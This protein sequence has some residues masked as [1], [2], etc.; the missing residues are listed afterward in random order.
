MR[1]AWLVPLTEI[2]SSA[3]RGSIAVA[4][5]EALPFTVKRIYTISGVSGGSSR[6][7]H[8]HKDL[9]QLLFVPHGAVTVDLEFRTAR[10]SFRLDSPSRGLVI[11]PMHWRVLRDFV[12]GT[13][14]VVGAS[15]PYEEM[16]YIRDYETFVSLD[17][18][19][20]E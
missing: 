19:G 18:C 15:H 10:T 20:R 5:G 12:N 2:T 14:L 9:W 8:A 6:G 11:P 3:D 1:K 7:H 13:V 16:D 4:E 17:G